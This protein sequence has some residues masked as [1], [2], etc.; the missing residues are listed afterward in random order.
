MI[1]DISVADNASKKRCGKDNRS[2][3][4]FK[5]LLYCGISISI[6]G[7]FLH[8]IFGQAPP[9][10]LNLTVPNNIMIL[11]TIF[12][13]I[14]PFLYGGSIYFLLNTQKDNL[15]RST[16]YV[17]WSIFTAFLSVFFLELGLYIDASLGASILYFYI[18]G[19]AALLAIANI[20]ATGEIIK[21][22]GIAKI[23][24][25]LVVVYIFG[26]LGVLELDKVRRESHISH[27][28]QIQSQGTLSQEDQNNLSR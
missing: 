5:L 22:S 13:S 27:S 26:R 28:V 2:F 9:P 21:L 25:L 6:L 17:L 16:I 12:S 24:L 18:I 7:V 1:D 19:F 4:W 8:R 11:L 3:Y 14:V 20:I 10:D 15:R 23:I